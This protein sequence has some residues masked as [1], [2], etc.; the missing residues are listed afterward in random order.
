MFSANLRGVFSLV[1]SW[2]QRMFLV[3]ISGQSLDSFYLWLTL[4]SFVLIPCSCVSLQQHMWRSEIV[5]GHDSLRA[6][7][8]DVICW[9]KAHSL[10]CQECSVYAKLSDHWAVGVHL[11]LHLHC[12][13][14]KCTAPNKESFTSLLRLELRTSSSYLHSHLSSPTSTLNT[15]HQGRGSSRS[16]KSSHED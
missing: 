14:Y 6:V 13:D 4:H 5:L 1:F 8:L 16:T 11:F 12:R 2:Q 9:D 15:S 7:Y 10:F 3:N